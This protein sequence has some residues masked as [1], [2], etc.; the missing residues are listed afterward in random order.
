MIREKFLLRNNP[1]EFG[2]KPSLETY[3]LNPKPNTALRPMVIV[4]PGG[5][6]SYVS[7]AWEGERV[8]LQY[9]AAGFCAATLDYCVAPHRYPEA[10]LDVAAAV[11]LCREKASE[12]QV[13]PEKIIVLGFSA[14]GHLASSLAVEWNNTSL[15]SQEEVA[16]RIYRPD[17]SILCYPVITSGEGCHA[18]SFI[19]LT[20]S[21]NREDWNKHS[22]EKKV[23]SDTPPT[24]LW[25]TS[26]DMGVP[27]T[28]SLLYA[29]A[30]YKNHVPLELHIYEKGGHG[31]SLATDENL[32][33]RSVFNRSYNWVGLSIDWLEE[34]F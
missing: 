17:Y 25:H 6:Y 14:G 30:L 2:F 23:T 15:F 28:N 26:E 18:G 21:E 9:T 19:N 3:I 32:R 13:D 24:F 27:M 20:G 31:L 10:L 33:N 12:W 11:K 5:A 7:E 1:T 16:S 34:H 22:N 4:C 29:D 8:A